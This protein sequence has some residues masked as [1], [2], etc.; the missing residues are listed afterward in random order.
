MIIIKKKAF[1][2]IEDSGIG[3][4]KSS[5]ELIFEEFAQAN[6]N[7]E[8]SYG[9]TGLG[10]AIS[11]KI[12]ALLG[13]ELYLKNSS[14]KGSTFEISL[15]VIFDEQKEVQQSTNPIYTPSHQNKT[16]V[17]VDD[18]PDLLQLTTEVLKQ[19]YKVISFSN[20][21]QALQ[22]LLFEPFDLLITDI[23]MPVKDGFELI[24]ELQKNKKYTYKNQ[25][26]IA[27]TGRTDLPNTDYKKL[28]F[29]AVLK[30]PYTP[31]ILL[32]TI[33]A[34]LNNIILPIQ[35]SEIRKT[36][37]QEELFSLESLKLFLNEDK[38]AIKTVIESLIHSTDSNLFMLEN[39][40]QAFDQEKTK[41]I[42]HKMAPMFKQIEATEIAE[43]LT[44]LELENH[45]KTELVIHFT[46]LKSKIRTLFATLEKVI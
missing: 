13:G 31:T 27:V 42:A 29:T 1:I 6:E 24:K 43:I 25:P 33:D 12:T 45:T 28:G 16:I 18:D 44:K 11:K 5:Q 41:Q 3:I 35:E 21:D 20:A 15:A 34:I 19:H 14:K 26:I 9:G 2:T 10:L 17:V 23:Q 40:I 46:N 39:T 22:D 32:Q 4:E 38:E 37:N 36:K 8:K 30:K 7:I